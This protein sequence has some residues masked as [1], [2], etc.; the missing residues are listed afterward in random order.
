ME[1]MK[2]EEELTI[3]KNLYK[4]LTVQTNRVGQIFDGIQV[5]AIQCE[6]CGYCL[7]KF[8]QFRYIVC[9]VVSRNQ[10]LPIIVIANNT[11]MFEKKELIVPSTITI[12]KLKDIIAEKMERFK[13]SKRENWYIGSILERVKVQTQVGSEPSLELDIGRIPDDMEIGQLYKRRIFA[14]YYPEHNSR[15]F[16][17]L[18][19]EVKIDG[20]DKLN[21]RARMDKYTG[22]ELMDILAEKYKESKWHVFKIFMNNKLLREYSTIQLPIATHLLIVLSNS[23]KKED[24]KESNENNKT[25]KIMT[26]ISM[27]TRKFYSFFLFKETQI[28]KNGTDAKATTFQQL[29]RTK[30]IIEFL[31]LLHNG[32]AINDSEY[33]SILKSFWDSYPIARTVFFKNIFQSTFIKEQILSLRSIENKFDSSLRDHELLQQYIRHTLARMTIFEKNEILLKS[34]NESL[35]EVFDIEYVLKKQ[36]KCHCRT[37]ITDIVVKKK[38]LIGPQY[39]IIPLKR[40]KYGHSISFEQLLN[41]N[42]QTYQL[43]GICCHYLNSSNNCH[44]VAHVR[45]FYDNKWYEIDDDN[46]FFEG[47]SLP[48]KTFSNATV[49]IYQKIDTR[50][51]S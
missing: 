29:E 50:I 45:R 3:G 19:V 22:K 4:Q 33:G 37:A 18:C 17:V 27:K 6:Y 5:K 40:G 34:L 1:S 11:A 14:I 25:I 35:Q 21:K 16:D 8:E 2:E 49:L 51:L 31:E 9:P 32:K 28:C 23:N 48:Q 44:N 47:I 39:L 46:I 36:F 24:N 20:N 41:L 42:S 10:V 12:Y 43:C 13:D 26:I 7:R 30:R 15:L 38:M